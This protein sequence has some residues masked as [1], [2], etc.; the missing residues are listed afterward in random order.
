[1][2][3]RPPRS[4]LFPYT[5]LFRS[6]AE[7]G[8]DPDPRSGHRDRGHLRARPAAAGRQQ[9]V[10]RPQHQGPVPAAGPGRLL[11][12]RLRLLPHLRP[13]PPAAALLP[14]APPSPRLP[15]RAPPGP[16]PPAHPPPPPRPPP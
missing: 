14:P 2:I 9:A 15:L 13:H 11:G 6:P 4:T 1:M 8:M 10:R 12:L 5:T 3:R 7:R 16:P